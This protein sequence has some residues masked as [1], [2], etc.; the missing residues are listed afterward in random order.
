MRGWPFPQYAVNVIT[1]YLSKRGVVVER[2]NTTVR[3]GVPQ[4]SVL[5]N[6]HY[7]DLLKMQMPGGAE[8]VGFADDVAVVGSVGCK[9][10]H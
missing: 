8:M 2:H 6:I 10:E 5:W 4:G 7:D 1:N 3:A 9:G